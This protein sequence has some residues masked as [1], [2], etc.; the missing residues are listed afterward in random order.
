[1]TH[2]PRARHQPRFRKGCDVIAAILSGSVVLKRFYIF[3]VHFNNFTAVL[4]YLDSLIKLSFRQNVQDEANGI[5][6]MIKHEFT[7]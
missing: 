2:R 4:M 5:S 1:M 7:V 6:C 3:I